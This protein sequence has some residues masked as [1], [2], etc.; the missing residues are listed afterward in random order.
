MRLLCALL[1][2]M[3]ALAGFAQSY[4]SRPIRIVHS[5]SV[6]GTAADGMAH[7]VGDK[8]TQAWGQ[9]VIVESRV[10]ANGTI[11]ADA[12]AHSAPDGYTLLIA[13]PSTQITAVF[14]SKTLPYDPVKDFTPL[15]GAVEPV[16]VLLGS[17]KA[18]VGSLR[19][20]LD[21]AKKNP[22]K[23]TYGSTGMG[24]VFHLTGE[25]LKLAA[26]IDLLHVPYKGPQQALIDVVG[27]QIDLLPLALSASLP[28]IR[29]GKVRALA[30]LEGRRY[31]RL[32]DVPTVGEA[33]PGFEKPSSWFA[34]F[35]PARMPDPLVNRLGAEIVR[36][37]TSPDVRERLD[38]GA[39]TL[40]AGTPQELAALIKSGFEIYGRAVKAAG[41]KPE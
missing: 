28:Q 7:W 10:G 27:G 35:G 4:P 16:T 36:A 2:W 24:S 38:E 41:L 23:L 29:A 37:L 40:V 8:L 30:V 13:S 26:G 34:F 22:G 39:M 14:L 3:P 9:P 20:M 31:E 19:E 15:G 25:S 33:V 17:A 21:Y 12:V 18:P 6:T 5:F 11:A 32:P 1:V